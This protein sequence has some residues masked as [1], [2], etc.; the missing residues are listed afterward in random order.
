MDGGPWRMDGRTWE[1]ERN[2]EE[3]GEWT[4]PFRGVTW[5]KESNHREA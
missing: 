3:L 5:E 1:N 2:L 4:E